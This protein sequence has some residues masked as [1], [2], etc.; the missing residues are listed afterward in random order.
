[1][2]LIRL[3]KIWDGAPHN[4]FTDLIRFNGC[5][6]C[7]FREAEAHGERDG[8][9]VRILSSPD[10]GQWTSAALFSEPGI[11]LR[12]PKFCV[13]PDGRLMVLMGGTIFRQGKIAGRQPRVTFSSNGQE[14]EPLHRILSDD[15]EWLWR[16]VWHEG[17]CY[18][19]TYNAFRTP[20]WPVKLLTST[21]GLLYDA[22]CA[23][24]VPGL[25]NEATVR[26][27]SD[28]RMVALLRREAGNTNAWVGLSDPPYVQWRWRECNLR[29]GGPNFIVLSDERLLA[30][31]RRYEQNPRTVAYWLDLES[32]RL[33]EAL[34]LPSGGDCSYAGLVVHDGLLWMSYYSS[35][36]GKS[37]I[38]LA[39]VQLD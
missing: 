2:E 38:Y 14:W 23:F 1:M 27:L 20:E 3:S 36:E 7:T 35:H 33:N 15:G 31:C 5:W 6:F 30:V 18:G 13:T 19:V 22:L 9:K 34:R 10:G 29:V 21:D 17:R 24:D 11:D 39:Q 8:G 12:D 25:P 32:A 16:V 37:S 26:F 28:G 4:A